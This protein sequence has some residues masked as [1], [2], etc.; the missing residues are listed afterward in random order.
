[1]FRRVALIILAITLLVP[2]FAGVADA[3]GKAV[4]QQQ[5][6]SKPAQPVEDSKTVEDNKKKQT[7]KQQ[8]E[9][10]Q[11]KESRMKSG[12]AL[13][14]FEDQVDRK[15]LLK[16]EDLLPSERSKAI[17]KLP[18]I[19][20]QIVAYFYP[21]WLNELQNSEKLIVL[22]W[23]T[24][25]VNLA[26][27]SLTA[28]QLKQ[29][30]ALAPIAIEHRD[31]HQNKKGYKAK[32]APL[33][34][35]TEE[36]RSEA[37]KAPASNKPKSKSTV[38]VLSTPAN[39][40]Y[41]YSPFTNEYSYRVNTDQLVDPLYRTANQ[42]VTDLSLSGKTGLAINLARSYNSLDSNI[43]EPQ[44]I[45][46][47]LFGGE[48][49]GEG[50]RG[51]FGEKP[52]QPYRTGF[53][54]T[55]WH[56]NLPYAHAE[57]II[58][59]VKATTVACSPTNNPCQTAGNVNVQT[60]GYQTTYAKELLET[61]YLKVAF[62]LDDGSSIE[63]RNGEPYR[64]PY[65]DASYT[66]DAEGNYVLAVQG[67]WLTYTFSPDGR[68][69][70]KTNA[71]GESV[72]YTYPEGNPNIIITDSYGRTI[73]IFRTRD[74]SL[75]STANKWVVTGFEV[76]EGGIVTK[77]IQYDVTRAAADLIIRTWTENNGAV[78]V[79]DKHIGYWQLDRVRDVTAGNHTLESYTYYPVDST[80]MADF[81]FKPDGVTYSSDAQG[82]PVTGTCTDPLKT[83][84]GEAW[85]WG[86]GKLA[87]MGDV[88]QQNGERYGEIAYLLLN[89]VNTTNGL[90][91]KFNYQNYNASW[92]MNTNLT[93]REQ[94]RGTTRLYQDKH[95]LQYFGYHA[96]ERVDYLYQQD[97]TTKL[98]S[99]Y[100]TNEHP[101][102][103]WQFNEYW[104]VPKQELPRLKTSSRFGDKQTLR[105]DIQ[106]GESTEASYQQYRI[107]PHAAGYLLKFSWTQPW[108]Y[109]QWEGTGSGATYT[110][111]DHVLSAFEYPMAADP[112]LELM[113]SQPSK[114]YSYAGNVT[115]NQNP[116]LYKSTDW[117]QQTSYDNWGQPLTV[118][119]ALDTT[120]T[121]EYGG[122]F[123]QVSRQ[124]T[125][126]ADQKTT[127]KTE[128]AYYPA[129]HKYQY[130]PTTVTQVQQYPNPANPV[131]QQS[132]TVTKAFTAYTAE[133]QVAA[134]E[135]RAQGSVN[136]DSSTMK[137]TFAYTSKGQLE[138]ET[139]WVRLKENE[140]PAP[141]T[142][143][144][145]YD[146][147][148]RLQQETYP[149]S[150][151]A[152]Y[153]YDHLDRI[154][155][156]TFI[157]GDGVSANKAYSIQYDDA[158]RK[159]AVTTPD[160]ELLES[161]YSPF[162][163]ALKQQRTVNGTTRVIMKNETNDGQQVRA[164][165][166]YGES[167]L[168]TAYTYDSSGRPKT[169]TDSIGQVTSYA[170]SNGVQTGSV[171][172][173][174]DTVEVSYPDGKTETSYYN[175]FGQLER[176]LEKSTSQTRTTTFTYSPAGELARKDV[177]A[178]GSSG[179][180]QTET[181]H[182]RYDALGNLTYVQDAAGHKTQYVYNHQGQVVMTLVNGK[183]QSQKGYNELGW[184][185]TGLDGDGKKETFAYNSNG[186]LTSTVDRN[187]QTK[188]FTYTPYMEPSRVSVS[189]ATGEI[190]WQEND[191]AP[192]TRLLTQTRTSENETLTYGYDEWNRPRTKQVAGRTY[193]F[194]YDA[195]DRLKGIQFPD[196]KEQ[197]YTY[198]PL[199][200]I[201]SVQYPGMNTVNYTYTKGADS[202]GYTVAY[203]SALKQTFN[204]NA[205]GEIK[206]TEHTNNGA[207][208]K[209]E[210]FAHDGFSNITTLTET[211]GAATKQSSFRYDP[212]NRIQKEVTP[213]GT[214]EYGY[215][216]KGNRVTNATTQPSHL[217]MGERKLTYN[218]MDM[219]SSFEQ[220]GTSTG[221]VEASYTY[222]GDGLRATKT[223]NGTLTR[224]VYVNGRV[225]EELDGSGN[226]K[227]RN[228]WGNELLWR[229]DNASQKSGYYWYNGHG[230]VVQITDASGT[231]INR[232]AYDIW[233]NVTEKSEGMSNPFRYTGEIQDDESGYIYLR[234]R[235]Y[236][237]SMGR[238]INEDSYEGELTNPLSQNFYTYVYN[239][240]LRYIDPSGHMGYE[241]LNELSE[242]LNTGK[243]N[244]IK[245]ARKV[246]NSVGENIS[247]GFHQV[248]Q[249]LLAAQLYEET[250]KHATLEYKIGSYR[251][252]VVLDGQVWEIKPFGQDPFPQLTL[253]QKE[254]NLKGGK[255][256]GKQQ[257]Q[258]NGTP[259]GIVA[260]DETIDRFGKAEFKMSVYSYSGG[261]VKYSVYYDDEN[262]KRKSFKNIVQAA[263]FY[264]EVRKTLP[265]LPTP[266]FTPGPGG[267]ARVPGVIIKI[268][269]AAI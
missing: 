226:V 60:S 86:D 47:N 183:L 107:E 112:A 213:E 78:G 266:N 146:A 6:A 174:K 61:F 14:S 158:K 212:L 236:D 46:Q 125:R 137:S 151:K 237:P 53:I 119:N 218:A 200:R 240:P 88:V 111:K 229:Q 8:K 35:T 153:T 233:G 252:D 89:K 38:S 51:N 192:T 128:T 74:T 52:D 249:L 127:V 147:T 167:T 62:T 182:Y 189:D 98:L 267:I 186:L 49:G 23:E 45:S 132:E 72:T 12:D 251:A 99:D 262:K 54:A 79:V 92:G 22:S 159:V 140:Q 16:K 263:S 268:I 190:Y 11:Q 217:P 238:F 244:L 259:Y 172:E 139:I 114:V 136:T 95:A 105:K 214:S 3:Q 175:R 81:N 37:E 184:Q 73:T 116:P 24:K 33:Y 34:E 27:N 85:S 216:G 20:K 199:S 168:Q 59:E 91:M 124:T 18:A 43:L 143:S 130:L 253:Y 126:S 30:E 106:Q 15:D 84:F 76:R 104:K 71:F 102:H 243:T 7:T 58:E 93:Q 163:L 77:K 94:Y 197:V 230:D 108:N 21:E 235:Y 227:A 221:T 223:V 145:Q 100:Y 156:S 65:K 203:S 191:Y 118:K 220:T 57:P 169:A 55:G 66:L 211:T 19:M 141:V 69:L 133:H 164:S 149:D 75:S 40:K 248:A 239:N 254:G 187:G 178:L 13:Q 138:Q 56:L 29:L 87:E 148:G 123:H 96:V 260:R 64:Y 48:N 67:G 154:R 247:L 39:D 196:Q 101:D 224:Y 269:Q 26:I 246:L 1:M 110:N 31:F 120:T 205:F 257:V 232:Y 173:M 25:E 231:E 201:E 131:E 225:I 10:A 9:S 68:I 103:G 181:T 215:D 80:K 195:Y 241:K 209:V 265:S 160:G 222:Y 2:S 219:L 194:R 162:G 157:P 142:L 97:G 17:E 264:K 70:K 50:D 166:P 117:I 165:L 250:G 193:T 28:A 32:H 180:E 144:Y 5:E 82:V 44:Y 36:E 115:D 234:A 185:L 261:D 171:F 113:L 188:A 63:F 208:S 207:A 155:S 41:V 198:D 161:F 202:N 42:A 109:L 90:T 135:E 177:K 152:E 228:I 83:C 122:P 245:A 4:G 170:Y 242:E 255:I 258:K 210:T 150:G 134:V 204:R 179:S 256:V 206:R 176:L 129:G 121:M